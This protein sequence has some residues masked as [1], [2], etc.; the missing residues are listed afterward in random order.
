MEQSSLQEIAKK[1]TQKS[2]LEFAAGV[3]VKKI[4][5]TL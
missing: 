1:F 4:S 5:S 3:N 2:L